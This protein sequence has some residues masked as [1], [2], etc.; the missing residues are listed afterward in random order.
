M[1]ANGRRPHSRV[2]LAPQCRACARMRLGV[3]ARVSTHHRRC[4]AESDAASHPAAHTGAAAPSADPPSQP[5]AP[6]EPS[7]AGQAVQR[8]DESGGRGVGP[9][10]AAPCHASGIP[11]HAHSPAQPVPLGRLHTRTKADSHFGRLAVRPI[12]AWARCCS[13]SVQFCRT[14]YPTRR[15][16]ESSWKPVIPLGEP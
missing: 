6:H 9:A 5:S 4:D 11:S 7:Q 14:A 3:H 8:R 13:H 1:G 10:A 15:C 12:P 16:A 2:T